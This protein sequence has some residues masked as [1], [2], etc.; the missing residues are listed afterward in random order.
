MSGSRRSFSGGICSGDTSKF[1]LLSQPASSD[2]G[3]LITEGFLI[4]VSAPV[5]SPGGSLVRPERSYILVSCQAGD[6]G[7]LLLA[8]HARMLTGRL[9]TRDWQEA[10]LVAPPISVEAQTA[11]SCL[12]CSGWV[13]CL[14][15]TCAYQR[16]VEVLLLTWSH[17]LLILLWCCL[18]DLCFCLLWTCQTARDCLTVLPCRIFDIT[19]PGFV[20]SRYTFCAVWW[21]LATSGQPAGDRSGV[22]F[23]CD[24]RT[25]WNP[26]KT[27]IDLNSPGVVV[28]D[29][30]IVPDMFGLHD[31]ND[32]VVLVWVLTGASPNIV[33]V[34]VPDDRTEPRAFHDLLI[35]DL[36]ATKV[37]SASAGDL[38]V[39]RQ[40]RSPSLLSGMTKIQV[41]ME[42]LHR[43]CKRKFGS[44][45]PGDCPHCGMHINTSLS[46]HVMNFHLA[47]GQLWG[48]PIPWCSVWK[49]T[50]QDC[51]DHLRRRHLTEVD[52]SVVAST[53]VKCFLPWTVTGSAWAAALGAKMS[54]MTTDV[55]LFSQH[56]AQFVHRYRVFTDNLLHQSLHGYFMAKLTGFTHQASAEARS[57]A[58]RGRESRVESTPTPTP[59]SLAPAHRTPDHALRP[60]RLHVQAQSCRLP[61][62]R[63]MLPLCPWV[64]SVFRSRTLVSRWHLR[65]GRCLCAVGPV[66][67]TGSSFTDD[68]AQ[69]R[70]RP[71]GSARHS[72]LGVAS[73]PS[74]HESMGRL[75]LPFASYRDYKHSNVDTPFGLQVHHPQFLEWVGAPESARLLD[76]PPG[77]WLRVMYMEQTLHAALQLQRD[78]SFMS[79][80]LN[81]LQQYAMS[82]HRTTSDIMQLVFGW[83]YILSAAVQDAA[84]VPRVRR[85][86]SH[87]AALG[88]W[89]PPNDPGDPG[90]EIFH[91]GP[92]LSIIP[93]RLFHDK[94]GKNPD[95]SLNKNMTNKW[96]T[97]I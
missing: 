14:W 25:S 61:K 82:L 50:A 52:S 86:S 43:D 79:S 72:L 29:T 78:A 55:M 59:T 9:V 87:M 11:V 48:C 60:G 26:S 84:L 44:G 88:L 94:P 41:D 36:S 13:M 56:S 45:R 40:H 89:R 10:W 74:D 3:E 28:L 47:L 33:R 1:S 22:T 69:N 6:W 37:W 46:R 17:V 20:L 92:L 18:T 93:R 35:E 81:V 57:V 97:N 54:G 66:V 71:A 2:P 96:P 73:S 24:I 4:V 32:E 75:S 85:A 34:L 12:G 51:V 38:T 30:T 39:L 21:C 91:Q 67:A 80:N 77:E 64:R 23:Q 95:Y 63:L 15:I 68:P 42:S 90:L 49:G 16:S 58:K 5:L 70:S 53:L 31:F 83:H 27:Y 19:V 62:P 8:T 65:L 76:R 7:Q